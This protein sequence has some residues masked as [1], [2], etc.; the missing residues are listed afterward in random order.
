MKTLSPQELIDLPGYGNAEAHLR[1]T[2]RW[3][4]TDD[5]KLRDTV[6]KVYSLA[7]SIGFNDADIMDALED[8]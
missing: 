5:D 8:I 6:D 1:K 7:E 4:K 2:N 3:D